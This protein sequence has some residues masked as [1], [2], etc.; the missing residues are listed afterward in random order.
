MKHTYGDTMTNQE[1]V[2]MTTAL[3][4]ALGVIGVLSTTGIA[5]GI[6]SMDKQGQMLLTNQLAIQKLLLEMDHQKESIKE[7]KDRVSR[8]EE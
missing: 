7:V 2:T 1:K 6:K 5:L 3:K 8:L 4:I